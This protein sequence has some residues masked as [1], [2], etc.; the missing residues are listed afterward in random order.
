MYKLGF[1]IYGPICRYRHTYVSTPPPDPSTVDAAK[2]KE[3]RS[4]QQV[5]SGRACA[6]RL[7]VHHVVTTQQQNERPQRRRRQDDYNGGG[8]QLVVHGQQPN[9][10]L[11]NADVLH[12]VGQSRLQYGF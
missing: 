6:H 4:F 9:A 5:N 10:S 8:G 2:P 1:C 12:A 3:F 11:P 7:S